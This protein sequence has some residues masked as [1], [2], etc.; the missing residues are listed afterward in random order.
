MF[1]LPF[2]TAKPEHRKYT[3]V[4]STCFCVFPHM[5]LVLFCY[6]LKLKKKIICISLKCVVNGDRRLEL[7]NVKSCMIEQ[8]LQGQLRE[9]LW[10]S[11]L[12]FRYLDSCTYLL[13]PTTAFSEYSGKKTFYF[14]VSKYFSWGCWKMMFQF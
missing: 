6:F 3:T 12:V 8:L 11:V 14:S 13:P 4:R 1:S 7:T 10:G 9:Y 2:S 5:A